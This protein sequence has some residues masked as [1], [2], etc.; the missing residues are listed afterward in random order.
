MTIIDVTDK[1]TG[2]AIGTVG[3][4]DAPAVD[5][6]VTTA[7]TAFK[8]SAWRRDAR[9]RQDALARWA[10][11]IAGAQAE[12]V[13]CLLAETGKIRSECEREV[14]FT[15]DALRFNA[16]M[17]RVVAGSAHELPDGSAGHLIREPIGVAAFIVPWNWPLFLLF[18]DLAP[19]LAAGVTAVIKPSP[20]TPLATKRAFELAPA[21]IPDDVVAIVNGGADVGSALASHRDVAGVSFTGS[22]AVGRL[23]AVAAA[24]RFAKAMLELGGKGVSVIFPDADI[25]SAI[26]GVM[27]NAFITAGQMCMAN[28]RV[29]VHRSILERV[30]DEIAERVRALRVGDPRESGIDIGAVISSAQA[31]RVQGYLDI[32]RSEGSLL[33]GGERLDLG[34]GEFIRPAVITGD[35]VDVR[36]RSEEIF[37]PVVT[38]EPFDDER[39]AYALANDTE[40]GLAAAVWTEN[41]RIAWRAARALHFGTVWVNRYNRTFAEVPSGGMKASG[42]GRT[43]GF[44]GIHEFTE[45]KHINFELG[46]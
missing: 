30:R 34:G 37:G 28:T 7:L 33:V 35:R 40:Y 31:D 38:V 3:E 25:D 4:H 18:R 24:Q 5:R 41:V 29:L 13:D 11:A 36:L 22:T 19:A 46:A 6:A 20:L 9:L 21:E 42:M 32:A 39:E 44:E 8:R 10:D 26:D 16:G 14:A 45:L 15:I 23:V 17:T 43:R 1:A 2:A 12:L 27:A